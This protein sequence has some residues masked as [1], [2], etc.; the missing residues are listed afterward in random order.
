M[1][2]VSGKDGAE[3]GLEGKLREG[4]RE[5]EKGGREERGRQGRAGKMLTDESKR[6]WRCLFS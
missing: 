2:A 1:T 6:R 4:L 3:V 5:E